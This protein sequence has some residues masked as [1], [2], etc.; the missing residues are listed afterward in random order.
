[1]TQSEVVIASA[2]RTPIGSFQGVFSGLTASDL[3]AVVVREAVKRAGARPEHVDR[4]I[5]DLAGRS[6]AGAP[7]FLEA[8]E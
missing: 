1:M 8:G 4:I 5:T 6:E 2:A 3:G 7:V